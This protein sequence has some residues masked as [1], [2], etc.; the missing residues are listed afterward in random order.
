MISN[1]SILLNSIVFAGRCHVDACKSEYKFNC[2]CESEEWAN[3]LTNMGPAK[4]I[5]QKYM[6]DGIKDCD[7][8]SDEKYCKCP[9]ASFQC[10]FCPTGKSCKGTIENNLYQCIPKNLKNN[11]DKNCLSGKD[12]E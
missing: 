6:C 10:S 2:K 4:C 5:P 8:N 3:N 7:D 12:E 11:S 1:H 9:S